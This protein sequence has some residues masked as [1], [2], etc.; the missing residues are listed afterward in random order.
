MIW[1]TAAS[2][3]ERIT[4]SG[5]RH[6]VSSTRMTSGLVMR[7]WLKNSTPVMSEDEVAQHE[8][9]LALLDG[10]QRVLAGADRENLVVV[11]QAPRQRAVARI[12]LLPPLEP[13]SSDRA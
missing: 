8:V 6:S 7:I 2:L 12:A 9:D 13:S 1:Y 4:S 10:R 3:I 11:F 5:S